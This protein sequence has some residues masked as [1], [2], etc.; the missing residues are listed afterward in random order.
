M[1][2]DISYRQTAVKTTKGDLILFR[3][4]PGYLEIHTPDG[5]IHQIQ[6]TPD[7]AS[8]LAQSFF[9]ISNRLYAV[10]DLHQ[11]EGK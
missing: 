8:R 2:H 6:S 11:K 3:H 9:D 4:Q 10:S 1:R 7:M 5:Q